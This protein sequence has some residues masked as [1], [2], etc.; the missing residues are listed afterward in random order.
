M[1]L[2]DVLL[3][4]QTCLW[5]QKCC[6][7]MIWFRGDILQVLITSIN[8]NPQYLSTALALFVYIRTL[9]FVASCIKTLPNVTIPN[10]LKLTLIGH[11]LDSDQRCRTCRAVRV[12]VARLAVLRPNLLNLAVFQVGWPYDIWPFGFFGRFF[13]GRLAENFFCWPFLKMCLC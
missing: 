4:V 10:W 2:R 7:T 5:F 1:D 9:C 13:E 8:L 6:P 12:R 11:V 3:G